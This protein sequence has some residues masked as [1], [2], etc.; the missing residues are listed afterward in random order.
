VKI[1][2]WGT[3]EEC[4]LAAER[5]MR[6]PGLLVLSVSEPRPDRGASV[7]VRVY[8]EGR[9]DAHPPNASSRVSERSGPA[10]PGSRTTAAA[11]ALRIS[12][13]SSARQALNGD[14]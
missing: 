6:T 2:L 3:E 5:L 9:L 4:R 11:S 12:A 14:D 7:L 1:R 10:A 13:K 8:I